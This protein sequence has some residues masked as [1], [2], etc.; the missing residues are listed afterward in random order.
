MLLIQIVTRFLLN[1][2]LNAYYMQEPWLCYLTQ[3]YITEDLPNEE[4]KSYKAFFCI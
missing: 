1:K 2:Y 4:I 3:I